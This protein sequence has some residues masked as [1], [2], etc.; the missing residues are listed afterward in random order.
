MK[1]NRRRAASSKVSR[2][3]KLGGHL[4]EKE[5]ADLIGAR[6]IPGTNKGDVM[7]T[8]S[9]LHSVKSGKKWQVFLYGYKTI[10]ASNYLNVLQPCLDAFTPGPEQYFKDRTK[11]IALKERF[12]KKHGKEKAKQLRN[13]VVIRSL[14]TNVYIQSK[15]QLALATLDVREALSD[16]SFLR[17][18]LG[19]AMFKD[20]EVT[21]LAV[22][23]STYKKDQ[24]FKVFH[25]DDVLDILSAKLLPSVSKAGR[26]PED[27]NV[28]G[29]KTLL[30]YMTRTDT[31]KNIV[32]IEVRND[33]AVHYRQ[34]RFNMYS[35]DILHL[36]LASESSATMN[37]HG[38]RVL[39][40]GRAIE[41]FS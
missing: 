40:Y 14:G 9:R 7:D 10:A 23:D 25:R 22:K 29:Q 36:L 2:D 21:Y 18:F 34:V 24:L 19:E 20:A 41:S 37:K 30:R 17:N 1:I 3:K 27:Y 15:E 33:S 8:Q 32:E 5:Y 11:C 35:K 16:K 13:D 38:N 4:R 31:L 12:V 26:V 6:R 39:V 28:E